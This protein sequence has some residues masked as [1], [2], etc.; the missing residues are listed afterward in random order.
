MSERQLVLSP[1]QKRLEEK[2]ELK[3]LNSRLQNYI[4]AVHN[5]EQE[6]QKLRAE[7]STIEDRIEAARDEISG[8]L[9]EELANSRDVLAQLAVEKDEVDKQLAATEKQLEET[10]A[11]LAA[12]REDIAKQAADLKK[13]RTESE[14]QKKKIDTLSSKV[15]DTD[16]A[17]KDLQRQLTDVNSALKTAQQNYGTEATARHKAEA[18]LEKYKK[19][20][21][22]ELEQ[23]R[24]DNAKLRLEKRDA[25]A[26]LEQIIESLKQE[27]DDKL[28]AAVEEAEAKAEQELLA[29]E[30]A[31][32]DR[33]AALQEA[34]AAEIE[35]LQQLVSDAEAQS[36]GTVAELNAAVSNARA[37][38]AE[39]EQQRKQVEALQA[40]ME[41][42]AAE[43]EEESAAKDSV[44]A[45][46]QHH[47]E[48][49]RREIA[50]LETLKISLEAEISQYRRLLDREESR[51]GLQSPPPPQSLLR[52]QKQD[53]APA[54]MRSSPL[55]SLVNFIS[56][57]IKTT[58]L[59]LT[60]SSR[61][62]KRPVED[63]GEAFTVSAIKM[64]EVVFAD[65]NPKAYSLR[66]SNTTSEEVSLHGWKLVSDIAGEEH[67]LEF[68]QKAVLKA[69]GGYKTVVTSQSGKTK[70]G[71]N[72]ILWK[73]SPEWAEDKTVVLTL[74]DD[75]GTLVSKVEVSANED[76]L[77][78]HDRSEN[79]CRLM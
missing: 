70:A 61:K 23:L 25:E 75:A 12:A 6:N 20:T 40:Q 36:G 46:E 50:D 78:S 15:A 3:Y 79:G 56:S 9:G 63:E 38:E 49:L 54:G 48:Q 26:D 34:H 8:Q 62:R 41:K 53:S 14:A 21:A 58:P 37:L 17:V 19:A 35:R 30:K 31:A 16:S 33:L 28:K 77:Q 18:E 47:N 27:A 7:V 32:D 76:L 51:L 64:G 44:I 4:T 42:Q 29:H 43:Y 45:E 24:S 72:E 68:P 69:D 74:Y 13:V 55:R 1:G 66:L 5:L 71:P 73:D 67:S 2:E 57:P 11:A 60:T 39:L 65:I 22:G 10:L 59:A 52:L